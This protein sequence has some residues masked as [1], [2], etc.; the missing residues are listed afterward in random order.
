MKISE[1]KDVLVKLIGAMMEGKYHK[2]AIYIEGKV[3]VGK[4]EA[5]KQVA[6]ELDIGFI[7]VRLTTCD[8]TDIRG[9]PMFSEADSKGNRKTV[10][11]P[12]VFLPDAEKESRGIL[13]FDELTT[14]HQSVQQALY[15]ILIPPYKLGEYQLP[16]GWVVISA[17]N[18]AEDKAGI[19]S[20][21]APLINR[22]MKL[23]IEPDFV[24]WRQYEMLKGC[25]TEV[26][27]YLQAVG[28]DN[29]QGEPNNNNDPFP[30]PRTW[31]MVGEVIKTVGQSHAKLP[32]LIAGL[33][34]KGCVAEFMAFLE[35]RNKI[36]D[37][38]EILAGKDLIATDMDAMWALTG[39]LL[40]RYRDNTKHA[41]RLV[42]YALKIPE[43][44]KEKKGKSDHQTFQEFSAILVR[45]A[46]LL[47]TGNKRKAVEKT[48][49]YSAWCNRFGG[50]VI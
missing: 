38:D 21:P 45:D 3:G 16:D 33:V 1:L 39:A 27:Y 4:S 6:K 47:D 15:Q 41:E 44:Y 26:L 20:M 13:F 37:P 5:V 29:W 19:H 8:P 42:E 7:D 32:E 12:P 49:S 9:L 36:P 31:E 34:G 35:L 17:G 48:K 30:T 22:M 46:F 40:S 25:P 24:E 50:F 14:A 43:L 18:R 28:R 23:E 2:T 11:L 10:W